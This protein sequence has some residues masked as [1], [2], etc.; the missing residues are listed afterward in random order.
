[1]TTQTPAHGMPFDV[2]DAF[3]LAGRGTV[4]VI[5]RFDG[6]VP[7]IGMDIRVMPPSGSEFPARAFREQLLRARSNEDK[8]ALLLLGVSRAQVPAGSCV[9]VPFARISASE[10]GE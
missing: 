8:S 2:L 3:E 4:V 10:A 5:R 7:Q 1:M 9:I 6:R